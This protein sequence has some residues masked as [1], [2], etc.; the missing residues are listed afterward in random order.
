MTSG[1]P[2][3]RGTDHVGFTVPNLDQA[4]R[5]FVDVIGW[6]LVYS[7]GPYSHQDEGDDW[8]LEHLG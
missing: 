5:F 4:E 1:I 3:L 7:L 2:G 8:M 6:T